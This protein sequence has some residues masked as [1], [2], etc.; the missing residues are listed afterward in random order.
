[1]SPEQISS[2]DDVDARSDVYS[3]GM[4]AYEILAGDLPFKETDTD[5]DIMRKVVE[6][7]IPPPDE[8]NP[9]LP[10]GIAQWIVGAIQKEQDDRYQSAEEMKE[11]LHEADRQ[12]GEKTVT[13]PDW[14]VGGDDADVDQTQTAVPG[15]EDRTQTVVPGD[16]EEDA[17]PEPG[18][19]TVMDPD[20]G[21]AT[22]PAVPD[23]EAAEEDSPAA[24][25]DEPP[26]DEPA[27]ADGP[28]WTL[29]GGGAVAVLLL[30]V[31]GYV[32]FTQM[33]GGAG[34][35]AT[36]SLTTAPEGALVLVN[37]DTAGTTPISR[38]ALD[39]GPVMLEVRKD[40][41]APLD[42]TLTAQAGSRVQLQNVA[43]AEA[44]ASGGTASD[45]TIAEN[46]SSPP[47]EDRSASEP[48]A[49]EPTSSASQT[50]AGPAS[51]PEEPAS[52][53]DAEPDASGT[54]DAGGGA[55]AGPDESGGGAA[56]GL[57]EVTP[58]PAGAVT[59]LVDGENQPGGQAIPL[60][61][62][63][64]TVACR[65]PR[66][67]DI[68]TTV[69]VAEGQTETLRCYFERDVTVN[70]TGGPWGRIWVDRSNT[71]E[72]TPSTLA[73]GPGTHR[74]EVRRET[75]DNF[76]VNGGAVKIDRG[77][78]SQIRQFSGRTYQIQVDPSFEKVE[79]AI[80]FEVG[81]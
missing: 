2:I 56:T 41:Y 18:G 77:G 20:M 50:D 19:Q 58:S 67:G 47:P 61:E 12:T 44:A 30:L 76:S 79:Y 78:E 71:G 80:N 33:G 7:K 68:E 64:H 69:T 22:Q 13:Q 11:A 72:D 57:V 21:G 39:A 43:L 49:A 17:V 32:A 54:S 29:V 24:A 9:D 60:T 35:T 23:P 26:A 51:T 27:D 16:D 4:T 74:I 59:V 34:A 42:T 38:Y 28:N 81:R 46:T 8:F 3:L 55:P 14:E 6:G 45:A 52:D 15:S 73:L 36:L 40:G 53:A 48:E 10:S 5:F 75:I 31:G 37:G 65:H 25:E 62:G 63:T 70:T 66:H 1:M